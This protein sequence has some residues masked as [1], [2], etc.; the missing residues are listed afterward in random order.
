MR[1]QIPGL[2]WDPVSKRGEVVIYL[3]GGSGKRRKH[4]FVA[5]SE[6]EARAIALQFHREVQREPE[7]RPSLVAP[8][9]VPASPLPV[10]EAPLPPLLTLGTLLTTQMSRFIEGRR[11]KSGEFYRA[12]RVTIERDGVLVDLPLARFRKADVEDF[13]L[14]LQQ[15]G[16]SSTTAAGYGAA[17]LTLL[18]WAVNRDLLEEF[19]I[20]KDV[21]FPERVKP[22]LELTPEEEQQL[23]EAFEEDHIRVALT[24]RPELRGFRAKERETLARLRAFFPLFLAGLRT[25]LRR[26]D[27]LRLTW[28][29][30]NLADGWI[31][32][33]TAKRKVPVAL[34]IPPD[35]RAALEWCADRRNGHDAVFLRHDGEP[36]SGQS[37]KDAFLLAKRVA[38]ITR[39]L[40]F[41][42]ATRHTLGSTLVTAGMTLEE[43]A[44]ILG[45]R[46]FRSTA[47][48]ARVRS[49]AIRAKFLD[50]LA[51]S[52]L[53]HS[54]REPGA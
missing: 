43:V 6:R 1:G 8:V 12:V 25:G 15:R 42:D 47:R 36:W 44:A 23:L 9:A 38:G 49:E 32:V 16:L 13:M 29:Q 14:R 17:I 48:Y 53:G 50:A 51:R 54:R 20:K 40:R 45:H 21:E 35:L 28:H 30:V 4:R 31:E 39:R 2:S 11:A 26:G 5:S 52:K 19:P 3:P 46:D 10:P 33:V 34:G 18:R 7:A 27:L 41:H 24:T 37:V 22:E